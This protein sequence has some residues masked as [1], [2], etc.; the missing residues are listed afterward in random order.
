MTGNVT[1]TDCVDSKY[2][3]IAGAT[4]SGALHQRFTQTTSN[5]AVY[6]GSETAVFKISSILSLTD[7][8]NISYSTRIGING[9]TLADTSSDFT[10]TGEGKAS[11]ISSQAIVELDPGDYFEMF[12]ANL[13][14]DANPI[15]VNLNII[16]IKIDT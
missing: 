6:N 13:T 11:S 15:C 9:T 12:V 14:N 2:I 16:A 7:G 5:R 1:E 4:T 8:N 3:K 10:S